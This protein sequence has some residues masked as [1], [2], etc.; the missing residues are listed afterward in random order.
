MNMMIKVIEEGNKMVKVI[1]EGHTQ[2]RLCE[3]V[4]RSS[5]GYT[6]F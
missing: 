1:E 6:S 5:C 2:S 3:N 4:K